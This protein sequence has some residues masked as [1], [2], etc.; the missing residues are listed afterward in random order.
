MMEEN[1]IKTLTVKDLNVSY[2]TDA[3]GKIIDKFFLALD[4][5]IK[6]FKAINTTSVTFNRGHIYLDV[7]DRFAEAGVN[8]NTNSTFARGE[9]LM[10]HSSYKLVKSLF[11]DYSF[12]INPEE[13]VEFRKTKAN[14]PVF[15]EI[16]DSEYLKI[17]LV[18][19]DEFT[20][21]YD[22]SYTKA[23]DTYNKYMASAIQLNSE[24]MKLAEEYS[25]LI[26]ELK[27]TEI[28]NLTFIPNKLE[29]FY[30]D[31]YNN[32]YLNDSNV[33]TFNTCKKY[34]VG[35]ESKKRKEG[36]ICT[37]IEADVYRFYPGWQ[38]DGSLM[39]TNIRM[40]NDT[41]ILEQSFISLDM[42]MIT[43]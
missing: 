3:D 2:K 6:S 13:F 19:G 39:C 30:N 16:K 14:N 15:L 12:T 1:K 27:P 20:F 35:F 18:E 34:I 10:E 21:D 41:Y 26:R 24:P 40:I 11:E 43:Q 22:T 9:V 36:Y 33:H 31:Y 7:E 37:D 23:Y 25:L 28:F 4:K 5:I 29:M 38:K 8:V 17:K 32:K 42:M